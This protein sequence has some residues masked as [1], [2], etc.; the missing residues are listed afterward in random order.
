MIVGFILLW[1]LVIVTYSV[2]ASI[3]ASS[4]MGFIKFLVEFMD[5]GSF[6][7]ASLSIGLLGAGIGLLF[8]FICGAATKLSFRI[9]KN[10]LFGVKNRL[11]GGKQ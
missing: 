4:A 5:T 8:L 3:I 1:V 7:M 11:V 10:I 2:E 9:T 6:N